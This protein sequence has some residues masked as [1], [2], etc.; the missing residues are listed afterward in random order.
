[1][2]PTAVQDARAKPT[3]NPPFFVPL[4]QSFFFADIRLAAA[5]AQFYNP[6]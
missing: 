1:M 3:L 2:T 4:T 6:R 5:A